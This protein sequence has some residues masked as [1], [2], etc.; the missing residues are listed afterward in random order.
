[1]NS[2]D[3]V[4][5]QYKG[6]ASGTATLSGNVVGDIKAVSVRLSDGFVLEAC[7]AVKP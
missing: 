7:G 5:G 6:N 2:P 3:N 1:V 4:I